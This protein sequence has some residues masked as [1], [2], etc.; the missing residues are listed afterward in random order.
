MR[1]PV[2]V[3]VDPVFAPTINIE[4]KDLLFGGLVKRLIGTAA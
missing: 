4:V 2:E 1:L 3:P